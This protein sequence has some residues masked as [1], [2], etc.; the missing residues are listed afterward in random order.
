MSAEILR[1]VMQT[2]RLR[3]KGAIG[4]TAPG[5]VTWQ[6]FRVH[7]SDG[8]S[9][10]WAIHRLVKAIDTFV[11]A[12]PDMELVCLPVEAGDGF[13]AEGLYVCKSAL[14]A[15]GYELE[16]WIA[17]CHPVDVRHRNAPEGE[18]R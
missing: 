8:E 16:A 1:E 10:D 11:R 4:R 2:Y 18:P 3:A 15:T 5:M 12:S 13:N 17:M 14:T 6:A 9:F 7:F